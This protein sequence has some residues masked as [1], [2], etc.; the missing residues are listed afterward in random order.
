MPAAVTST[1]TPPS[2]L[3]AVA[4]MASLSAGVRRV[5][6]RERGAPPRRL[7]LGDGLRAVLLEDVGDEHVGALVGQPEAARASDAVAA[8]GDD[9]DLALEAS[10]RLYSGDIW[11]VN[12]FMSK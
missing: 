8:A 3:T 12:W 1:S 9:R 7:H 5:D 2:S 4:I 11:V 10:H 6:P